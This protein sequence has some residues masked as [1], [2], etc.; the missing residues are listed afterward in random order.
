MLED[1]LGFVLGWLVTSAVFFVMLWIVDTLGAAGGL[2][3]LAVILGV[4]Y[5]FRRRERRAGNEIIPPGSAD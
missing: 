2:T 1:I 5:Y 4:A 3:M